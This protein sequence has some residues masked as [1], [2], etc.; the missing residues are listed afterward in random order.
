[1][2]YEPSDM[3]VAWAYVAGQWVPCLAKRYQDVHGRSEREWDI[4]VTEWRHD[5]RVVGKEKGRADGQRRCRLHV[6][7]GSWS[8]RVEVPCSHHA[9]L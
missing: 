3:G 8:H 5:M 6:S 7:M 4:A 1:V 9:R 2:C